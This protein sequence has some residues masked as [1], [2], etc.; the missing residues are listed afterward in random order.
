MQTSARTPAKLT[1]PLDSCSVSL[2]P[3]G[4][5]ANTP[6]SV[7]PCRCGLNY[8]SGCEWHVF[9]P[10]G[11]VLAVH[12]KNSPDEPG[13]AQCSP[14]L[15]SPSDTIPVSLTEGQLNS[16]AFS[17]HKDAT[18]TLKQNFLK[19]RDLDP[20]AQVQDESVQCL[21]CD[22]KMDP[23]YWIQHRGTCRSIETRVVDVIADAWEKEAKDGAFTSR[24]CGIFSLLV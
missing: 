24:A 12:H 3:K 8:P 19:Q 10:G 5:S 17:Y 18:F 20:W 6:V 15:N 23:G 9:H 7:R 21:G 14:L 13:Q 22:V 4:L 1:Q 11:K 16:F 2:L